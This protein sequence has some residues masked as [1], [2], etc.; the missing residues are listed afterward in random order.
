MA[1]WA[2]PCSLRPWWTTRSPLSC[3]SAWPRPS[4]L[5]CPKI[6]N[7]PATNLLCTP[8][9]SMYWLSRN[10]TRAWAM[11]NRVVVMSRPLKVQQPAVLRVVMKM[12]GALGA[13]HHVEV[14][15][16]FEKALVRQVVGVV[17]V[18]RV[19]RRVP[20]R[21]AHLHHQQGM[22]GLAV[23]QDVAHVAGVGA[24][25]AHAAFAL[26]GADQARLETRRTGR[27]ADRDL[28]VTQCRHLGVGARRQVNG[29]GRFVF[30]HRLTIAEVLPAKTVA[31]DRHP[32]AEQHQAQLLVTG[33]DRQGFAQAQ[34]VGGKADVVQAAFFEGD[35]GLPA[36]IALDQQAHWPV[37]SF[38]SARKVS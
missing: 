5:P 28:H 18:R 20:G 2:M 35:H 17:L 25:A 33:R 6:V 16:F 38:S 22:G 10:S 26:F 13:G 27:G 4:T 31:L 9:T 30:K 32:P 3:S 12:P 8:S 19:A 15:G 23:G 24:F 37:L 1:A 34:A 29:K 7:T 21:R 36:F 14:I 11:V